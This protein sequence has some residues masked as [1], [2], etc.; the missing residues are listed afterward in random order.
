MAGVVWARFA[1]F[2]C[3]M[4]VVVDEIGVGWHVTRAA[5]AETGY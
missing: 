4:G 2:S 3:A 5:I 1:L